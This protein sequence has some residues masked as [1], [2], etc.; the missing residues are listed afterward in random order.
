[1]AVIRKRMSEAEVEIY[2][3]HYAKEKDLKGK[4]LETRLRHVAATRLAALERHS[5]KGPKT[6]TKTKKKA[7]KTAK[8]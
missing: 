1:M 2:I 4:E 6:K 5:K 8:K 7:K 3:K